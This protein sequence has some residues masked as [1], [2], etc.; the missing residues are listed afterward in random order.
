[1]VVAYMLVRLSRATCRVKCHVVR[2]D[3]S[4]IKFEELKSH[5]FEF[6]IIC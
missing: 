5:L 6:Y 2:R 3:S 1:M 4:A